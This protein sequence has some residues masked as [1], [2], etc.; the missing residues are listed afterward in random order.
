MS[1]TI[2][3]FL[4][5]PITAQTVKSNSSEPSLSPKRHQIMTQLLGFQEILPPV[6][7][8]HRLFVGKEGGWLHKTVVPCGIVLFME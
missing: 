7:S 1:I 2:R 4:K 8:R 5:G 3:R 6:A